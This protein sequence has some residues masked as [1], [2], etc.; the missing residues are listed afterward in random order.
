MTKLIHDDNKNGAR[1][2]LNDLVFNYSEEIK[3]QLNILKQYDIK[4][5]AIK[6]GVLESKVNE[7]NLQYIH[8]MDDAYKSREKIQADA[9]AMLLAQHAL[10]STLE[11]SIKEQ[12]ELKSDIKLLLDLHSDAKGFFKVFKW[13][14]GLGSAGVTGYGIL[15][16]NSILKIFK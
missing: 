2:A 4:E 9:M 1:E 11:T 13:I 10:K 6:V 3:T 8:A 15:N 12:A 14:V 16:I 5:L 7:Q